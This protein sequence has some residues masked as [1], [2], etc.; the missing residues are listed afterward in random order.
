[1]SSECSVPSS[2]WETINL[3]THTYHCRHA[4]GTPSDYCACLTPIT[5]QVIGFSDHAPFPDDRYHNSRMFWGDLESYLWEIG[6]AKKEFPQLRILSGLEVEW[7]PEMGRD[8]YLNEYLGRYH[9]DYLI[10]SAHF[11]AFEPERR[12]L[13]CYYDTSHAQIR[14]GFVDQTLDTIAS[15]VFSCLA[16]TDAYLGNHPEKYPD[17]ESGLREIVQAAREYDLP[18][19]LN[20]N[21]KR[22]H[23]SYPY[24]PFWDMVREAKL[25]VVIASDA[26]HPGELYDEALAATVQ[27]ARDWELPICNGELADQLLAAA[28]RP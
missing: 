6:Q 22:T 26:H 8:F 28:D 14:R 23:R 27:L 1:M 20:A 10:G 13:F 9:L 21:G 17:I 15:G 3:H 24:K 5:A 11:S 25:R 16:H 7:R 18:L 2:F 4:T 12:H 19:E